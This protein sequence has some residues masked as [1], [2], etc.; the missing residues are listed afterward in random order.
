MKTEYQDAGM[1]ARLIISGS[2]LGWRKHRYLVDTILLRVPHLQSTEDY[3][4]IMT[5][6]ISGAVADILFAEIIAEEL[7]HK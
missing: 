7:G 6:V 2:I 5:T 1:E 4:F 3:Q